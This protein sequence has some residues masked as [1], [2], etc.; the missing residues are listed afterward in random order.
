MTGPHVVHRQSARLTPQHDKDPAQANVDD[1]K[2]L[3]EIR[4]IV[5]ENNR[6]EIEDD[7]IIC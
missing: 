6:S 5:S 3:R 4:A 7:I 2:R 1:A